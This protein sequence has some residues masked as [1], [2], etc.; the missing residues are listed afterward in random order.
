MQRIDAGGQACVVAIHGQGVLGQVIGADGQKVCVFGQLLGHQRGGGHF[1]HHPQFGALRQF[2]LDA[3]LIQALAD[4]QQFVHLADHRQQDAATRQRRD[5]QQGTQL[6]VEQ[7]RAHLGQ[8]NAAQT[9]HRVGFDRQRQVVELLVAAHVDGAND[10]G[11]V[12]HG[13]QHGLIGLALFLFIRRGAAVDEQKFGA[14]QADAIGAVFKR[15]PRLAAGGDV[16]GDFNAHAID[17]AC[18]L[19]R[20]G[21]LLLATQFLRVANLL[22]FSMARV[23]GGQF[24]S[25]IDG[26]Q[27]HTL[28]LGHIQHLGTQRDHAGQAFTPRKNGDV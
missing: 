28:A 1:D 25:A 11:F 27:H 17:G 26:V 23:C 10:H 6:L 19:L 3:Q 13:I 20:L 18:R 16:G 22:H 7:F 24:Q 5:L 2:Q 8:A 15:Q 4:L 14:Q 12:A 9:Q 21:L